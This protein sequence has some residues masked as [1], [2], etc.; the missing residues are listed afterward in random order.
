MASSLSNKWKSV[1]FSPMTLPNFRIILMIAGFQFNRAT[2][3]TYASIVGYEHP[4]L[5][6]YGTTGQLLTGGVVTRDDLANTSRVTWNNVFWTATG[7]T[8][9]SGGAIIYEVILGDTVA[10]LDFGSLQSAPD[11]FPFTIGL[12][13]IV[14]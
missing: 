7:G 1:L 9:T 14:I 12:I 10:F 4:N 8:I 6:G 11:G 5:F 13:S 2:H 3:D